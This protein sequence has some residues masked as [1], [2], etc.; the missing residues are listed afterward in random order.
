MLQTNNTQPEGASWKIYK[1]SE[2]L[3]LKN[4][5][6]F[7]SWKN[8]RNGENETLLKNQTLIKRCKI[9]EIERKPTTNGFE[10]SNFSKKLQK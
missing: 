9:T 2:K 10:E 6:S 8:D 1:L 4:K 3:F 5:T 7:E